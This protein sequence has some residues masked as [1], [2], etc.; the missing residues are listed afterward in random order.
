MLKASEA[1]KL[2]ILLNSLVLACQAFGLDV[3]SNLDLLRQAIDNG[4]E[5]LV[6]VEL[7]WKIWLHGYITRVK[8]DLSNIR[9][10]RTDNFPFVRFEDF[11]ILDQEYIRKTFQSN[12]PQF[13]VK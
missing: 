6:D 2:H 4:T 10:P 12:F 9:M 3:S 1:E 13:K 8:L 5:E 11:S 7:A